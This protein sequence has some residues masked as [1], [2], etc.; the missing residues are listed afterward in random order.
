MP[1]SSQ[2]LRPL[3]FF[4]VLI[5]F[6][7]ALLLNAVP[8]HAQYSYLMPD[9]VALLLL[10]WGMNQ[11]KSIGLLL[12]FALGMLVDV[13]IGTMLG[14]HSL[15][16]LFAVYVV[17][18]WQRQLEYFSTWQQM[19]VV[20]LLMFLMQLITLGVNRIF[21]N[22]SLP[23]SGYFLASF[24]TAILW[25]PLSNCLVLLQHRLNQTNS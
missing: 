13:L 1:I 17:L 2:I 4:F 3:S 24:S 19:I 8:W 21:L 7:M 16:Y 22:I 25:I 23:H 18:R 20:W 9:F 5:S 10:Y 6:F 11:P 12:T 15:A 14:S